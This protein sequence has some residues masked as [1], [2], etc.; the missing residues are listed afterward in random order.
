[1]DRRQQKT[2]KAIFD[3]FAALLEEESYAKITVQEIVDKADIGRTTFY[4]HFETKDC[5][6][7]EMCA[8]LFGHVFSEHLHTEETHDF[9]KSAYTLTEQITHILYH[10]RDNGTEITRLLT[11]ESADLF[12][13]HLKEYLIRVFDPRIRQQESPLPL[14]YRQ[15]YM[16]A[17]F[18]E[19]IR[20]WSDEGMKRPPEEVAADY[21]TAITQG[22]IGPQ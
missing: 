3:A 14:S 19:T 4:A 11:G 16:A 20:W 15:R 1:M 22:V 7:Q 21:V 5:L 6:L 17:S 18:A 10:L 9:S 2:R 12:L 13:N 8:D